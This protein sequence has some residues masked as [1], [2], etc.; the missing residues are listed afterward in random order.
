MGDK[1]DIGYQAEANVIGSILDYPEENFEKAKRFLSS[2]DFLS[3]EHARVFRAMEEFYKD[4]IPFD[5]TTFRTVLKESD[6]ELVSFLRDDAPSGETLN[7]WI[8]V[9]RRKSLE[10]MLRELVSSEEVDLK[11]FETVLYELSVLEKNEPLCIPI[12]EIIPMPD[13]PE[14]LISMGLKDVDRH[15]R[16]S[17]GRFMI[18]A[19]MPKMGKTSLGL[20]MLFNISKSRR[21]GVVSIEMTKEEIQKRVK[22]SFGELPHT[23]FVSAPPSLSTLGLKVFAKD[24]TKKGV[25]VILV[26]YLQLMGEGSKD[27]KSRHLEISYITRQVKELTKGLGIAIVMI[28]SLSKEAEYRNEP[29]MSD[30][31]ESGDI[32]YNADSILLI[33]RPKKQDDE[34]MGRDI[35]KIAIVGNRWGRIG[36]VKVVWDGP[37]TRFW[38]YEK[39]VN[40]KTK[41]QGELDYD[42]D[43]D[44]QPTY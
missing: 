2:K 38:N 16:L 41:S 1:I 23:L 37:R 22:D 28:S 4:S 14:L 34:D 31:K 32:S 15:V 33:Y 26:D 3:S 19:G 24:M 18:I 7:F 12:D 11:K 8:R 30:L 10:R 35:K 39:G 36:S 20:Q 44:G 5:I 29:S 9:V 42:R 6:L 27:F 25:E 13:D 21:V 43:G 40:G 17:P